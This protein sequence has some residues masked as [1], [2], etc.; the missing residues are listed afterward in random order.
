LTRT[1]RLVP[2]ALGLVFLAAGILKI[3]D[4]LAFAV[5]IARLRIAPMAVVGPVAILLPWIEVVA[6]VALLIPSYRDAALKL[7]MGMLVLFTAILG[8]GLLRGAAS[9][10]CFGK[11]DSLL[12]RADVALARNVVLIALAALAMR[13]KTTSP[14][15]PASPA[16]GTGR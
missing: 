2:I 6:A 3:V 13:R 10:G 8:I 16:S 15:A 7:L 1:E 12:N 5:S 4:P 9:C 14:A 11:A